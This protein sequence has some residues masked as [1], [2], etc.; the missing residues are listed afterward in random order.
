MAISTLTP[1]GQHGGGTPYFETNSPQPATLRDRLE[2][3]KAQLEDRL[4]RINEALA[5]IDDA[6]AVARALDAVSKL[7]GF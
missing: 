4:N 6:P 2:H 1:V 5:A 3:E 7:G